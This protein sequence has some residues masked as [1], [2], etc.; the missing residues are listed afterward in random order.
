M[1]KYVVTIT[2]EVWYDI[3]VES[4]GGKFEII[5]QASDILMNSDNPSQYESGW[6]WTDGAHIEEL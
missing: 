2:K 6:E 3:E 5:S 4:D 1:A